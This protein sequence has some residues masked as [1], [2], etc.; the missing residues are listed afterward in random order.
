MKT[1]NN[2]PAQK[3]LVNHFDSALLRLGHHLLPQQQLQNALLADLDL[4]KC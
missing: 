4:K 3:K 2:K 1:R